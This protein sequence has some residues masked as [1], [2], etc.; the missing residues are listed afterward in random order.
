LSD[1]HLRIGIDARPLTHAT[2]GIGRYTTEIVSRLARTRHELFLYAH[3]PFPCPGAANV[4][5]RHGS[6]EK[7]Q[8]ASVFAQL[9]F[10]R[11]GRMDEIDIFW[12]P[13]HHLPLATSVPAVVTIHDMV[14]RK[15][16]ESMIALGRVLERVLMPP[17]VKK[18]RAEK[19]ARRHRGFRFDQAGSG[20]L[21]AGCRV[22]DHGDSGSAIPA[23]HTSTHGN[24]K[25]RYHPLCRHFR[26]P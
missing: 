23:T 19:S 9:R 15:A 1:S 25:S 26:T 10:P 2:S 7:S 3:Q 21:P 12:S 5:E 22:E 20:R 4:H 24:G 17:S 6:L 8:F 18:A 14:W 11:W 13:R 16:P